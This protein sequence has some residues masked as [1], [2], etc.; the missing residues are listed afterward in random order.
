MTIKERQKKEKSRLLKLFGGLEK[1]KL[2]IVDGLIERA[3][4][5]R[6]ALEDLEA[7][8]NDEGVLDL[9]KQGDYS[10]NREHPALKSYNQTIKNYTSVIKQLTDNLPSNAEKD[11]LLE[12]IKK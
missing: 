1:E 8:V 7:V 11:E 12:F 3:A 2:K 5:M 6:V 4:F 10:Y 9:F